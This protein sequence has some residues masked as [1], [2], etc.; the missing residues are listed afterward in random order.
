MNQKRL[1]QPSLSR[2]S[3]IIGGKK[4]KRKLILTATLVLLVAVAAPLALA[5]LQQGQIIHITKTYTNPMP[6]PT[7]TP[8]ATTAP[9]PP[10]PAESTK[11]SL[12]YPNGTAYNLHQQNA[13]S[14]F[15]AT[16]LDVNGVPVN[17]Q[18]GLGAPPMGYASGVIVVRNDGDLPIVVNATLANVSVP[19]DVV[20]T[21]TCSTVN[22]AVWGS[23]VDGWMG[24]DKLASG[25]VV[26]AGEYVWL[27][28][29]V[30]MTGTG[31]NFG[32][33]QN[34]SSF[35]YSFDVAINATQA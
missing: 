29:C 7:S 35:S 31:G 32:A 17:V 3:G 19:A 2:S 25:S 21:S 6:T 20:L 15:G 33:L 4:L 30:I 8:V 13:P 24:R 28:L 23:Q 1:T 12:W 22:P 34:H 11:F 18:S 10:Q 27:S 14:I 26:G 16:N 9:T 5:A